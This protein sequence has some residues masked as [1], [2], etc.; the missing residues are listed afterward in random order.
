MGLQINPVETDN[1]E[2]SLNNSNV[3]IDNNRYPTLRTI[4]SLFQVLAMLIVFVAFGLMYFFYSNNNIIFLVSALVIGAM[5]VLMLL[6]ASESIKVFLDIE[7]N[8]RKTAEK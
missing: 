6:A 7:Y 8:T 1:T 3:E 2:E 4:A 5:F